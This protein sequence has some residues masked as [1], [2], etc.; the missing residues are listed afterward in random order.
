MSNYM[1]RLV[2]GVGGGGYH[3]YIYIYIYIYALYIY[4]Y[5]YMLTPPLTDHALVT[6]YSWQVTRLRYCI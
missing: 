2:L 1:A 5:M 6:V 3:V 4:I